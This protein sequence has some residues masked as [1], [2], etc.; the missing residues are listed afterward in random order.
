MMDML[1]ILGKNKNGCRF[2]GEITDD[3]VFDDQCK[4]CNINWG[5]FDDCPEN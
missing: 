4:I 2:L 5:I 3:M 1:L